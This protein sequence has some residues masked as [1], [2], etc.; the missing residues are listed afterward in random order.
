M[1]VDD[2]ARRAF[3]EQFRHELPDDGRAMADADKVWHADGE[4]DAERAERLVRI[5][6][7]VFHMRIVGLQVGNRTASEFDDQ[8]FDREPVDMVANGGDFLLRVIPPLRHMRFGKP[9]CDQKQVSPCD[10]TKIV[11]GG[12][13]RPHR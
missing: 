12:L 4:V 2:D 1:R 8:R 3:L 6:V 13:F 10:R 5:G 7:I 9:P 11:D